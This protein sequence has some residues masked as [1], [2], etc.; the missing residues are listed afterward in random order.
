[1]PSDSP[2]D[3]VEQAQ[4]LRVRF[5]KQSEDSQKATERTLATAA[6]LGQIL[7]EIERSKGE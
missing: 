5:L 7:R 2:S 6:E 3:L 4:R 1:M